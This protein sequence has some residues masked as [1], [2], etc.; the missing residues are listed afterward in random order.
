MDRSVSTVAAVA[1]QVVVVLPPRMPWTG[2]PRTTAVEGGADRSASVAAGLAALSPSVEVVLIHDA[3][4]PL[5]SEDLTRQVIEAVLAGADAALP[6]LDA[7]DVVKHR[8][9]DGVLETVGR[10]GFGSAQ[11]P[12]GFRRSVLVAARSRAEGA[13]EDSALVEAAGG[14]VVGVPGDP[15]NVHVVDP[16]SLQVARALAVLS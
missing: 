10:D 16:R 9:P 14:R 4:H 5:A 12:M 3:A 7:A 13:D 2:D 15:A 1:S 8:R 11:M 6:F